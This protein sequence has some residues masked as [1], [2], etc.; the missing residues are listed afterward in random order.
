M[1]WESCG[2][3]LNESIGDISGPPEAEVGIWCLRS[4]FAK[5][6]A[7]IS[8]SRTHL[9]PPMSTF[10]SNPSHPTYSESITDYH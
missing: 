10:R 4:V 3:V 2:D 5:D 9:K 1:K 8:A 6:T 7:N